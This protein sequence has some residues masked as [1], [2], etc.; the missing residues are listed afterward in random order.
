[1]CRFQSVLWLEQTAKQA[2]FLKFAKPSMDCLL[3][4]LMG[5]IRLGAEDDLRFDIATQAVTFGLAGLAIM[6][7]YS[8]L[9]ALPRPVPL[10]TTAR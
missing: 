1:M 6:V 3:I 8:I 5:Y 2:K 9:N 10:D 7:L 4:M